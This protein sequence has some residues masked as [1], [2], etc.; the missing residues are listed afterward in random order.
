MK[1]FI[2]ILLSC[3][4]IPHISTAAIGNI[5][6]QSNNP[7]S[8]TRQNTAIIGSKGS[9]IEMLDSIRTAQGKIGISFEDNTK[10]HINENSKLVIDN[11]VYDPGR[12]VG[13]LTVNVAL[14]TVKYASGQIAK[15]DPTS[16]K[17][18]T[19][20]ATISVRGT[21]FTATVDELGASTIILLPSCPPYWIDIERDC[22]T[23]VISV[24]S[25]EGT[26]VLNI[27]FQA[28]R[29]YNR[30]VSPTKP[31]VLNLTEDA[32]SNIMILSPPRELTQAANELARIAGAL[33]ID[34]LKIDALDNVLDK[35]EK[36]LY[37]DKLSINLLE[38]DFL[39]NVLDILAEQLIAQLKATLKP[40]EDKLLPD[41]VVTTGVVAVVDNQ[42]VEL[43]RD[44]GNDIQCIT[45]PITQN[46]T[47]Y[48]IQGPI[49]I[50]NRINSGAGTTITLVQR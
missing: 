30:G 18:N 45:T 41:Y 26:V 38:T 19:P 15:S 23:G 6:D 16:V 10:V 3:I 48:T 36:G 31:V 44:T 17:V 46:S 47:V 21:D 29:V 32:I 43:C 24:S 37:K 42:T 33:D 2:I 7:A 8:I 20:S 25:D 27:A 35:E 4:L 9:S 1:F 39:I 49:E 11:F 14:G 34:F 50:R 28:T 40:T 13:K 12:G 22:I 5:T